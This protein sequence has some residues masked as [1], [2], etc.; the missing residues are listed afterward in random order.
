MQGQPGLHIQ[1]QGSQGNRE[2]LSKIIAVGG[3]HSN[4]MR[5][6]IISDMSILIVLSTLKAKQLMG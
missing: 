2:T 4:I 5:N 3:G 1:L 6:K